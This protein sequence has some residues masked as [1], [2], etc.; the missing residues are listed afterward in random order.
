M[1]K[2]KSKKSVRH[3]A[4]TRPQSQSKKPELHTQ[5][6]EDESEEYSRPRASVYDQEDQPVS[7]GAAIFMIVC[8][9]LLVIL[10][11]LTIFWMSKLGIF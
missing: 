4:K 3:T 8:V 2:T 9:I 11:I 6:E 10:I 7:K 5:D 1:Q